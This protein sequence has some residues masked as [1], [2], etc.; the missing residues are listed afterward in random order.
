MNTII[1]SPHATLRGIAKEVS[2]SKISSKEIRDTI[3]KMKKLLH[4]EEDGVAIA[5]PQIDVPLRIFVVSK[6]VLPKAKDDVVFINPVITKI[7]KKKEMVSEGCLSVRWKYGMVKRS[8][9]ATVKALNSEG[10]EFVMSGKGLL[11]Q[12]FQHE[13]DHLNGVLFIDKAVDVEDIP[14]EAL[15]KK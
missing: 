15:V 7:G 2:I 8:L 14:P 4:G 10:N 6:K 1:Q 13:T 11:A 3:E 9:T 5:A 12:I